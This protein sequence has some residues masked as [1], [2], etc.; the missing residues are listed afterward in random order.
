MNSKNLI[1][2]LDHE[3]VSTA[4]LLGL[5]PADKLTW[6]P[7]PKAMTLGQLANHVATIPGRYLSFA[8]DGGTTV[9]TLTQHP[10]PKTKDE[11]LTNFKTS[12][13]NAKATLDAADEKWVSRLCDL[14]KDGAVV[15]TLPNSLFVRL[16]VFNH[17]LHHRGQLSTYLRTLNIALPS[18]YGPSADEDPFA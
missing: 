8:N 9:E 2:E 17:L 18:I 14:V 13:N 11:I 1:A 6:Q 12:C 10:S 7:H 4:K 15:F 16:L 3:L 5:V